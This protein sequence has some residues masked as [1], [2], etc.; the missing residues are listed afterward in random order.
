MKLGVELYL[1]LN[2]IGF[3]AIFNSY[4]VR[5]FNVSLGVLLSF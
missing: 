4:G 3:I 1:N 5:V 2:L